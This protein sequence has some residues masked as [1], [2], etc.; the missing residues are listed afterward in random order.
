[1]KK[2]KHTFYINKKEYEITWTS[3]EMTASFIY[4]SLEAITRNLRSIANDSTELKVEGG[5][6]Y[7]EYYN[8]IQ[9]WIVN[10]INSL[11][12]MFSC[13]NISQKTE[14]QSK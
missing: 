12:L 4:A 13:L 11:I 2:Y 14:G 9:T 6:E 1:M 5:I 8:D 7:S 10:I 3:D